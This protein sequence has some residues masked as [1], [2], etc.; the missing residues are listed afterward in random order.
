MPLSNRLAAAIF[1]ALTAAVPAYAQD[2]TAGEIVFKRN[3]GVCHSPLPGRNIVGPSLFGIIGRQAG[4]VPNFKY[5]AANKA[6]DI[7]WDAAK[8][9]PY[10][11]NPRAVVPATTM[12][13]AGLKDP[14]QRAD[15]IAYLE[16]LK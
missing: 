4:S 14:H 3:C 6:S 7:T 1:A 12:A 16:T 9:E 5:S 15:V 2:A 10:L 13:Y 8:L 11:A